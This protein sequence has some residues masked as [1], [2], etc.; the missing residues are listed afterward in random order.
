MSDGMEPP[1]GQQMSI[2]GGGEAAARE[3]REVIY[4][5]H[6]GDECTSGCH[7][8]LCAGLGHWVECIPNCDIPGNGWHACAHLV[9]KHMETMQHAEMMRQASGQVALT[10]YRVHGHQGSQCSAGGHAA[11]CGS[12][13]PFHRCDPGGLPGWFACQHEIVEFVRIGPHDHHEAH[14]SESLREWVREEM[15]RLKSGI[16]ELVLRHRG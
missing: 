5:F 6:Q 14:E 16:E 12:F 15:M 1:H 11:S 7:H 3:A 13:G 8:V 4:H 9:R 10:M 2:Q